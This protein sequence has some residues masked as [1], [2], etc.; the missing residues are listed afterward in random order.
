[1][2]SAFCALIWVLFALITHWQ[3][4]YFSFVLGALVGLV[5]RLVTSKRGN[6]YGLLAGVLSAAG[7]VLAQ[8]LCG[9]SSLTD[10]YDEALLFTLWPMAAFVESFLFVTLSKWGPKAKP[11]EFDLVLD[12]RIKSKTSGTALHEKV[13]DSDVE[14]DC[15][16][17]ASFR[18]RWRR[19][20]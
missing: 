2:T 19:N 12:D 13:D 18:R 6:R 7:V 14:D 17:S 5:M 20:A 8:Y 4:G 1:L 9:G 3:F 11:D 16:S 10:E 15:R